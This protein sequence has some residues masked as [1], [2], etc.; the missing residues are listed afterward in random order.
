M[1]VQIVEQ[2]ANFEMLSVLKMKFKELIQ[3]ME[4]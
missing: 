4:M 2:I 3:A 1:D